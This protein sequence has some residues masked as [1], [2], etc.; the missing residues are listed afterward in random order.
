MF[1]KNFSLSYLLDDTNSR[2]TANE[3][4]ESDPLEVAL[5]LSTE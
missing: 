4:I 1:P 5:S 2:H 3:G